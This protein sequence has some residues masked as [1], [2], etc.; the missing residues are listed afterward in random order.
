M[1]KA[2]QKLHKYLKLRER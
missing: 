1:F 2:L